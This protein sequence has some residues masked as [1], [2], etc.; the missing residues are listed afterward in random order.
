MP[1]NFVNSIIKPIVKLAGFSI[2]SN[3]LID[4]TKKLYRAS[5]FSSSFMELIKSSAEKIEID[6]LEISVP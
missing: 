4:C 3:H 5:F 1:K 6:G 2:S